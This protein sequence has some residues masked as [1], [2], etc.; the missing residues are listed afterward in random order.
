M[1]SLLTVAAVACLA[2]VT[3]CDV[4]E[5]TGRVGLIGRVQ[6]NRA[7]REA[8]QELRVEAAKQDLRGDG[9][10]SAS[11]YAHHA[12]AAQLQLPLKQPAIRVQRVVVEQPKGHA[13][14]VAF[15]V[16]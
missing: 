1:K 9:R 12:A 13:G 2:V 14:C 15:F 8:A 5:A 7:Q 6:N 11:T 10:F 4:A 3:L 16:D